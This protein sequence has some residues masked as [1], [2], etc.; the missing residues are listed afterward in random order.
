M[1]LFSTYFQKLTWIRSLVACFGTPKFSPL[2]SFSLPFFVHKLCW[3]S[4]STVHGLNWIIHPSSD[5][6]VVSTV[7]IVNTWEN[8]HQQSVCKWA[9]FYLCR[10]W[11]IRLLSLLIGSSNSW[12]VL[13]MQHT[14]T[15]LRIAQKSMEKNSWLG[16]WLLC[17]LV[18]MDWKYFSICQ[19]PLFLASCDIDSKRNCTKQFLHSWIIL[20]TSWI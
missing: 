14:F 17:A 18:C 9:Y 2:S 3:F 7:K 6:T 16:G 13:K 10:G 15:S 4:F 20:P 19:T 12:S 11:S 8:V 5:Y 1:V